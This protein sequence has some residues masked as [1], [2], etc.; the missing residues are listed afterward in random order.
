M[1][2]HFITPQTVDGKVELGLLVDLANTLTASWY[3]KYLQKVKEQSA[4]GFKIRIAPEG[5]SSTVKAARI[6][7][8]AAG[9]CLGELYKMLYKQSRFYEFLF[10]IVDTKDYTRLAFG[11]FLRD[12]GNGSSDGSVDDGSDNS[13]STIE[14]VT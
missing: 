9:N 10:T 3:P 13:S 4:K 11:S 8:Y 5:A 14:E 1:E 7:Q 12:D 2:P 6:T